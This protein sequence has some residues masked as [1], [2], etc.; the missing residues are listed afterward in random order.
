MKRLLDSTR[1]LW[2]VYV[3]LLLVVLP[4]TAWAFG[5][6]E[7]QGWAWLGWVAAVAF[8]GAIAAFTW[9]LKETI[10]ATPRHR[11]RW[12]RFRRRYLNVHSLGLLTA[13]GVSSA[14]NWA[15]SVQFGQSF[16][17][18]GTYSVPPLL[19]S[20]AFGG[21]LPLCSLLFA[22]IL[23]DV[24]DVEA[25]ADAELMAAKREANQLRRQLR[26]A[27]TRAAHAEQR[28]AAAGDLIARI[29]SESKRDRI[30]A[31]SRQWPALPA[32]AIAVIADASPSYVSEVLAR[33]GQ[34][35]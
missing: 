12:L 13:I 20:L 1:L 5:Q 29:L 16:A 31:A 4:H 19:Y 8:E 14:A 6:F 22:R 15:H 34:D 21:I 24:R 27:E 18:F 35:A 30:L 32:S 28:F 7:P 26:E 33:E 11:D 25:E 23:A 3:A 2:L 17:V 9:R 10:E